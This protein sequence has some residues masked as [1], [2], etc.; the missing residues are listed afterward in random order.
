LREAERCQTFLPLSYHP[1]HSA[2][3]TEAFEL[4]F[5]RQS[6]ELKT[7]TPISSP[8]ILLI[9]RWLQADAAELSRSTVSA[10][11]EQAFQAPS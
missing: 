10:A 2:S 8:G 9:T 11:R 6:I 5:F 1:R 7:P 4:A 3:I